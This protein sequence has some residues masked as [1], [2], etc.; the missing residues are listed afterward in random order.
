MPKLSANAANVG[1]PENIIRVDLTPEMIK[2]MS[3]D[4]ILAELAKLRPNREV[5]GGAKRSSTPKAPK[6]EQVDDDF[7]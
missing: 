4:Q 3:E 5:T 2:E 1:N 7:V 6:I